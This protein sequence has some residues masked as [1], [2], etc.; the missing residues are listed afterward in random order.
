[1]LV[2]LWIKGL[3]LYERLITCLAE[4]EGREQTINLAEPPKN[5]A[6][7]PAKRILTAYSHTQEIRMI[8]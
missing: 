8:Y 5:D 4:E 1:M 3:S 2:S 6:E 7:E